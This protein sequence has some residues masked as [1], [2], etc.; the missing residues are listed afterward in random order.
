MTEKS[1]HP[2][3]LPAEAVA[4]KYETNLETGLTSRKVIELQKRYPKNELKGG[5]AIPWYTI[6][7][8]QLINA[9]G[10]VCSSQYIQ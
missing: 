9:M 2:F 7:L 1:S 4:Q 10:L 8:K 3:L 5:G 6:F